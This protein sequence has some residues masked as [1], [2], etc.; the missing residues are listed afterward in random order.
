[1]KS[2][3]IDFLFHFDT[4]N[5]YI[6]KDN[7]IQSL[8]TVQAIYEN[9][10]TN[11]F[12]NNFKVNIVVLPSEMGSLKQLIGIFIL[13]SALSS[14]IGEI[15][16][17][18]L[19]GLLGKDL[20]EYGID[21]G[22]FAQDYLRRILSTTKLEL[23]SL[24]PKKINIDKSIK[25]KSDFYRKLLEDENIRGIKYKETENEI[26]REKFIYYISSDIVRDLDPE[27][28]YREL[29]IYRPILGNEQR[30]KWEFI[31]N[32]TKEKVLTTIYDTNFLNSILKGKLP[33]KQSPN[34]DIIKCQIQIDSK[35]VN[36][37]TI[38]KGKKLIAVYQYNDKKIIDVPND[39]FA[40]VRLPKIKRN[41]QRSLLDLLGKNNGNFPVV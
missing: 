30:G 16:S 29:Q 37:E 36:G 6:N 11:I 27:F 20:K 2:Q 31:D 34:P 33:L 26:K 32:K 39:F 23:E 28:E 41:N 17:G 9:L 10:N 25:Y 12:D 19:S 18:F 5:P 21:A 3:Y 7:F 1:M 8:N 24:I 22:K 4:K 13:T 14:P 40:N 15:S 35:M 38:E